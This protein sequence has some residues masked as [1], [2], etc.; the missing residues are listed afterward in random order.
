VVRLGEKAGNKEGG[1]SLGQVSMRVEG[2][3]IALAREQGKA[4]VLD[5]EGI[6]PRWQPMM[7]KEAY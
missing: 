1:H 5:H 6:N 2:E 4:S 7:R 3:A